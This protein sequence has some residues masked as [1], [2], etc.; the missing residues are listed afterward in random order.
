MAGVPSAFALTRH[1][2]KRNILI[3]EAAAKAG[4]GGGGAFLLFKSEACSFRCRMKNSGVFTSRT[5]VENNCNKT[6]NRKTLKWRV[7]TMPYCS[8]C[9]PPLFVEMNRLKS[10]SFFND[11]DGEEWDYSDKI[12]YNAAVFE[13]LSALASFH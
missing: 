9:N 12:E 6:I 1:R 2:S 7:S 3:L 8:A 4:A 10:S 11:H 5:F 13:Q